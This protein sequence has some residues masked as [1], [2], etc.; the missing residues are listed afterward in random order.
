MVRYL[1]EVFRNFLILIYVLITV[2]T[3]GTLVLFIRKHFWARWWCKGLLRVAGIK[4]LVYWEENLPKEQYVFIANHQ[5]LLDIPVLEKTLENYNIRFLAKKSLFQIP[6]FGWGIK[7]LGYVPIE[8]E[9]P[10]KGLKSIM[11]CVERM[12]QGISMV[13]FP[14]GTRS[15]TGEVLPFKTGGFLIPLKTGKKIVPVSILG[16]RDILPKGSLWF[17][18]GATDK[19]YVLIRKPVDTK[20]FE[21][22]KKELAEVVR[23][24]VIEGL[25]ILKKKAERV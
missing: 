20:G 14:E 2:P 6:F 7:V 21:R 11:A 12:K 19:V 22:K 10:K 18:V 1:K 9:D 3:F 8:R 16:T 4:V 15:P 24:K 23:Q 25:E 17:R 13:V 5:S